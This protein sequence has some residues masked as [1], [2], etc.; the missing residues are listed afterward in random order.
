MGNHKRFALFTMDKGVTSWYPWGRY[1]TYNGA[2]TSFDYCKDYF[3][4]D[5]SMPDIKMGKIID[6]TDNS[7]SFIG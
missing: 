3:K 1:T 2:K 5:E 7:V 6:R 4:K